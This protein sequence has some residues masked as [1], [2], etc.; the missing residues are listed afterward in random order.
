MAL[1]TELHLV[2]THNTNGGVTDTNNSMDSGVDVRKFLVRPWPGGR[3][4]KGAAPGI[5]TAQMTEYVPTRHQPLII[6][7][8]LSNQPRGGT[9]QSAASSEGA[10]L[11]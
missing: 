7:V 8:I 5:G 3:H 4:L 9:Q 11:D 1:N 10:A 6:P 2:K